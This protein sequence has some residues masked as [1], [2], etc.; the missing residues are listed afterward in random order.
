MKKTIKIT[1]ALLTAVCTVLLA[2]TAAAY[3]TLPN[4]YILPQGD[5]VTIDGI[6][7][8]KCESDGEEAINSPSSAQSR[9]YE[10]NLKL[11]NIIPIKKA[12]IIKTERPYVYAG[13][14]I[15]GIRLYTSGV[16]VVGVQG[17][18]TKEWHDN[19]RQTRRARNGGRHHRNKRKTGQ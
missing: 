10:E 7:S 15:F 6:Y 3:Y 5:T 18:P 16:I 14:N 2:L 9:V 8:A 12:K 17:V 11:F 1:A 13:G 4:E 19:S